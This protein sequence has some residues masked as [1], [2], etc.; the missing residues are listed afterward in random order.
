MWCLDQPFSSWCNR[1]TFMQLYLLQYASSMA[2]FR[3]SG[4]FHS[5]SLSAVMV[6]KCRSRQGQWCLNQWAKPVM[7][8]GHILN[9]RDKLF[10]TRVMVHYSRM[11]ATKDTICGNAWPA[12]LTAQRTVIL[13]ITG[14]S[15]AHNIIEIHS[16]LANGL[17]LVFDPIGHFGN[18]LLSVSLFV[19]IEHLFTLERLLI[20]Q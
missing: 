5:P 11:S 9:W 14:I 4:N 16:R 13:L 18:R 1:S 15:R 8:P 20:L 10:L 17:V 2:E 7:L 12:R 19:S 3:Q 6:E